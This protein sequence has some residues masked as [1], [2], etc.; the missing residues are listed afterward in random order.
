MCAYRL[1]EA[2]EGLADVSPDLKRTGAGDSLEEN[3]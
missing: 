3:S 2:E 1:I